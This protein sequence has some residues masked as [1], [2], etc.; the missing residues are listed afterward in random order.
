MVLLKTLRGDGAMLLRGK[1][2]P[3][4]YHIEAH[5][6]ANSRSARGV[7]DGLSLPDIDELQR[8]NGVKLRLS[9]G[10]ELDFAFLGGMLD[11]PQK[12][13]VNTRLPGL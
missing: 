12:F 8:Y 1:E 11:G 7:A 9:D 4:T 2:Y 6:D 13:V 10:L 5:G 3:V